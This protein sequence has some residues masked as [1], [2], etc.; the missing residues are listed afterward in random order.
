MP[1][2]YNVRTR[3]VRF[4]DCI[5]RFFRL[6]LLWITILFLITSD[7]IYAQP[8]TLSGPRTGVLSISD[9]PYRLKDLVVP[10]SGSLLIE[11]GV[12]LH[13]EKSSSITVEGRLKWGGLENDPII[14]EGQADSS[15]L[16]IVFANNLENMLQNVT[17]RYIKNAGSTPL[18]HLKKGAHLKV[19][20]IH[21]AYTES[22]FLIQGETDSRLYFQNSRIENSTFHKSI[23]SVA[24]GKAFVSHNLFYALKLDGSLISVNRLHFNHNTLFQTRHIVGADT[25]DRFLLGRTI[26][27]LQFRNNIIWP[28]TDF[29]G[30]LYIDQSKMSYQIKAVNNIFKDGVLKFLGGIKS[31]YLNRGITISYMY[32]ET[33]SFIGGTPFDPT[34]ASGSIGFDQAGNSRRIRDA[35]GSPSDL[36]VM[37]GT[38]TVPFRQLSL[39]ASSVGPENIEL[40]LNLDYQ[41]YKLVVLRTS[42]GYFHSTQETPGSP[43]L[44]GSYNHTFMGTALLLHL[45]LDHFQ[46]YIG[47]AFSYYALGHRHLNDATREA[48]TKI[49]YT[50]TEDI[51][52]GI[53]E[54][55]ALTGLG[56]NLYKRWYLNLEYRLSSRN[57][58]RINLVANR[59]L[60]AQGNFVGPINNDVDVAFPLAQFRLNIGW[61]F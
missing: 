16:F 49:G 29:Q 1:L 60:I 36:G 11:P 57:R 42:I 20:K 19:D 56:L 28:A 37:G 8:S 61:V 58:S 12:R 34:L 59:S 23:I 40:Y 22:P 43:P 41:L 25:S 9:S 17:F 15:S 7:D 13:L 30:G 31:Y 33:P 3:L 21:V 47:P 55:S 32:N 38:L 51:E 6:C 46:V 27:S 4:D 2:N 10:E 48:Y 14:F 53:P 39:S 26:E 52:T 24:G 18:I 45:W 50:V 35:D 54:F 5:K 44:Q